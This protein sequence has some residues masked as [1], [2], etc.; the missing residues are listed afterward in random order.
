MNCEI[1]GRELN[2]DTDEIWECDMCGKLVCKNCMS[3]DRCDECE[4][5]ARQHYDIFSP[6]GSPFDEPYD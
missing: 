3:G 5:L 2:E 6:F 4:E 1:C